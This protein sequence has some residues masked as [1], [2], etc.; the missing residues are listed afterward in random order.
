MAKRILPDIIVDVLYVQVLDESFGDRKG[1]EK[2]TGYK[3]DYLDQELGL[4]EALI[5]CPCCEGIIRDAT[6]SRGK[7]TCEQ[8]CMDSLFVNPIDQVRKIVAILKIKCPLSTGCEWKGVLAEVE[9]HMKECG[10][11]LISCSLGCDIV[12]ER[13]DELDHTQK[14]CEFRY[15]NCMYCEIEFQQKDL[16]DHQ[17]ICLE[18]PIDCLCEKK[19]TL[20]EMSKHIEM[21]CPLAVIKCPYAKYGCDVKIM[22]R[23]DLL[24]HKKDFFIEHQDMIEE[25]NCNMRN[26]LETVSLKM[27][28]K[29][30]HEKIEWTIP[31]I[32]SFETEL[33][34]PIIS[35]GKSRFKLILSKT[36]RLC[37]GI[38]RLNTNII[39]DPS[40]TTFQSSLTIPSEDTSYYD[41]STV[42]NRKV[43]NVFYQLFYLK[44]PILPS[45]LLPD[46]SI[47]VEIF[48]NSV[49]PR[50]VP[51][52]STDET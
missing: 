11:L 28:V 41:V 21:D 4:I 51:R 33:E 12:I 20:I 3:K 7:I 34:G 16:A 52:L 45:G 9:T 40:V 38:K 2:S 44:D 50:N 6:I 1:C 39:P 24:D 25:Q 35:T 46:N 31:D 36:D 43:G 26:Q 22:L 27:S 32:S 18:R 15:V 49:D 47:V 37:F 8:C 17:N 30:D 14:Y 19:F 5:T 42:A 13:R 48:F 29:K 23:K 10:I